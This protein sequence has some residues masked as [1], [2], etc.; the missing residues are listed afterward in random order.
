[1]LWRNELLGTGSGK[2]GTTLSICIEVWESKDEDKSR[3]VDFSED[4]GGKRS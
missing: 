1:M 3:A 2:L 4:E